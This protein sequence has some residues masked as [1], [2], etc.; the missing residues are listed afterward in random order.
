MWPYKKEQIL[1]TANSVSTFAP[2]PTPK[3]TTSLK[4]KQKINNNI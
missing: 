4:L 1:H 3:Q 2:A